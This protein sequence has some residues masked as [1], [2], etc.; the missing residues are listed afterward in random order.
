MSEY[1]KA[2]ARCDITVVRKSPL[3]IDERGII[4]EEIKARQFDTLAQRAEHEDQIRGQLKDASLDALR[5][6]ET[7]E[8]MKNI[9]MEN[10][11]TEAIKKKE[12]QR[13]VKEEEERKLNEELEYKRLRAVEEKRQ[14]MV[15]DRELARAKAAQ[16][17]YEDMQRRLKK[18]TPKSIEQQADELPEDDST[19][20]Y[21]ERMRL[22]KERAGRME[23]MYK[24]NSS[25]KALYNQT[26]L[27]KLQAPTQLE[28]DITMRQSM[29]K[30]RLEQERQAVLQEEAEDDRS[31]NAIK[32]RKMKS[33]KKAHEEW[34]AQ[35][36]LEEDEEEEAAKQV[37]EAAEATRPK[38]H[39]VDVM[40]KQ[41]ENLLLAEQEAEA[42]MEDNIRAGFSHVDKLEEYMSLEREAWRE[43][44]Q[45][46]R[47][48][49]YYAT[50]GGG[51][52]TLTP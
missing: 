5:Q 18:A 52:Q 28:L 2:A 25:I 22:E 12:L 46:D 11:R 40:H 4:E 7:E 43:Q 36:Q 15:Q 9:R 32:A 24:G 51:P 47:E 31:A 44:F 34:L 3:P 1:F 14:E 27:P 30:A 49:A 37:A 42:V 29:D 26:E 48:D 6:R 17:Q 16:K 19:L 8:R 10:K 39:P 50:L 33:A 21:M 23:Q 20:S 13:Q 45:R 35:R 41:M 38:E